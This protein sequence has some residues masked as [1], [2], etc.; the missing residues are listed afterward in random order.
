MF[1]YVTRHQR[2]PAIHSTLFKSFTTLASVHRRKVGC[3]VNNISAI[4]LLGHPSSFEHVVGKVG[5][6]PAARFSTAGLSR[7]DQ[8]YRDGSVEANLPFGL[9]APSHL[10]AFYHIQSVLVNATSIYRAE[11]LVMNQY[12][13]Y[14]ISATGIRAGFANLHARCGASTGSALGVP[15]A[16]CLPPCNGVVGLCF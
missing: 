13:V 8:F 7:A 3:Q 1:S 14:G 2:V 4:V 11:F 5:F 15:A 9:V 16:H 12:F 10:T 6:P